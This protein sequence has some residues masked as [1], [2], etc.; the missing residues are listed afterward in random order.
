MA[1]SG[2]SLHIKTEVVK[3]KPPKRVVFFI[4]N[5]DDERFDYKAKGG[6]PNNIHPVSINKANINIS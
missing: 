5:G 6:H 4:A 1:E 3:Q 2:K